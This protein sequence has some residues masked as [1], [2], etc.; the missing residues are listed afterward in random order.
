MSKARLAQLEVLTQNQQTEIS[1]LKEKLRAV[2]TQST[3]FKSDRDKQKARVDELEAQ[4]P[5]GSLILKGDEAKAYQAYK[6]LGTAEEVKTKLEAAV[7]TT[8]EN[9]SLKR[10][11][12]TS[13][14]SK[15]LGWKESVLERLLGDMD[16]DGR[17]ETVTVKEG[18]KDVLKKQMVYAV[19]VPQESGEPK[20]VQATAYAEAN[21]SDFLP[22]LKAKSPPDPSVP[23]VPQSP[24]NKP[25]TGG[26][27]DSLLKKREEN[28]KPSPLAPP[29]TKAA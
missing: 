4:M 28:A 18:G 1:G 13:A 2:K 16:I 8:K 9:T 20:R 11:Q 6:A 22:A 19:L 29:T 21:W 17:E 12:R 14:A 3:Q 23:F 24:S 26:H 15:A 5:E 7:E 25:P 10:T 27:L